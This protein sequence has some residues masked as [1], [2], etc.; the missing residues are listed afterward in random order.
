M[1][2][3]RQSILVCRYLSDGNCLDLFFVPRFV[4]IIKV[5]LLLLFVQ[6]E[7]EF[8]A[9]CSFLVCVDVLFGACV[10]SCAI[11]LNQFAKLRLYGEGRYCLQLNLN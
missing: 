6:F 9:G 2:V 5:F 8:Y 11:M 10:V 1:V 4:V 3:C 7:F